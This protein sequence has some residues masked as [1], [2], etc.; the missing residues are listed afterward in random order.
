VSVA[1][2]GSRLALLVRTGSRAAAL[3]LE[4]VAETMRPLPVEAVAGMPGCMRGLALIRGL[5]VPVIHLGSLLGA[6]EG[7]TTTRLVTLRVGDRRVALEVDAVLGV[8]ELDPALLQE[9]PLLLRGAS[10]GVVEAIGTL[11]AELLLVLKA[12]RL[13]PAEVW[14]A[15]AGCEASA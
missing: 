5:P 2:G 6:E 13:V 3:P 1:S 4:N 8:R 10:A 11:D 9:L 15:L 14:Q 7:A 12:S